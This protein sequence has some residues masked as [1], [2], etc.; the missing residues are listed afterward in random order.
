MTSGSDPASARNY[1]KTKTLGANLG[2]FGKGWEGG[3]RYLFVTFCK[4]LLPFVKSHIVF[5]LKLEMGLMDAVTH[6]YDIT[7]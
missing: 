3:G 1:T 2:L 6:H 7:E 4:G 5:M